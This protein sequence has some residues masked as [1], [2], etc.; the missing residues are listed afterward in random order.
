M[1]NND[2]LIEVMGLVGFT[3]VQ[4]QRV[5]AV[6]SCCWLL[7]S[8]MEKEP[9]DAFVFDGDFKEMTERNSKKMLGRFLAD[10]RKSGHFKASFNKRFEKFVDRRN[11]LVHRIFKEK[12]YFN[13]HNKKALVRLHR[14]VSSVFKDAIFFDKVFDA[15]LGMSFQLLA[16]D[17]AHEI[18]DVDGLKKIMAYKRE[19]GEFA[20]LQEAIKIKKRSNKKIEAT[21]NSV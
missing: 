19:S 6:L 7:Y 8:R 11:R 5:E 10:I 21:G 4:I 14:F 13:L 12:A 1:K 9:V 20:L 15:Y 17:P 18:K 2:Y 16:E 3:I